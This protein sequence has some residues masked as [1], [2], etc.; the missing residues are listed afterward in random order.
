M[1]PRLDL[2]TVR[3][4]GVDNAPLEIWE[5]GG[6]Q[7]HTPDDEKRFDSYP[8]VVLLSCTDFRE[9]AGWGRDH[10]ERYGTVLDSYFYNVGSGHEDYAVTVVV[11]SEENLVKLLDTFE[12]L[13][14]LP[15]PL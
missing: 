13:D 10:V 1:Q 5:C 12:M 8:V 15:D 9:G 11:H 4:S 7:D 2:F 6:K 3:E 14:Y